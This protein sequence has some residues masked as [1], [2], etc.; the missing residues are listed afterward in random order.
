M[1]NALLMIYLDP[2]VVVWIEPG[3][4]FHWLIHKINV[5]LLVSTNCLMDDY[6]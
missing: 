4:L 3:S 6:A 1:N 5:E 2:L